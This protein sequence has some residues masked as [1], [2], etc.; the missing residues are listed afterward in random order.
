MAFKLTKEEILERNALLADMKDAKDALDSSVQIYN[1]ALDKTREFIEKTR[2]RMQNE[3]DEK[4]E[5]WQQGDKG[6]AVAEMLASWDEVNPEDVDI[7]LEDL[8]AFES[9]PTEVE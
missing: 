2:E 8:G 6:A 4:S 7:D 9:L 1:Q 3:F 5:A